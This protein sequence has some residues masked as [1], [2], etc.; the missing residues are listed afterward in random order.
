[1]DPTVT[2]SYNLRE[3]LGILSIVPENWPSGLKAAECIV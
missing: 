1:M 2:G 3:A